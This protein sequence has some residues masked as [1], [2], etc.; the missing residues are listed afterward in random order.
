MRSSGKE[1]GMEASQRL[2]ELGA[3]APK[4]QVMGKSAIVKLH[5]SVWHAESRVI[6][7]LGTRALIH[8]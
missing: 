7:S 4:R 2:E 8:G 1:R 6:G 5:V 3:F